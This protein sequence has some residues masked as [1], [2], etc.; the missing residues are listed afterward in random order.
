MDF[1]VTVTSN[2]T[3]SDELL[4]ELKIAGQDAMAIAFSDITLQNFGDTGIARPTDW[5][6][7]SEEYAL[8]YHE[9]DQT[10]R[11]ILNGDLRASIDVELGNPEYAACYTGNPYAVAQQFGDPE[12][13]LPARPFMPIIGSEDNFELT[14]FAKDACIEAAERAMLEMLNQ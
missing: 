4:N 12:K 13:H 11:L 10:P 14:D 8:E 3:I 9:G 2:E 1:E 5:K 7:L 6:A